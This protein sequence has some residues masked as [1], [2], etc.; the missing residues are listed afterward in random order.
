MP[1]I[2]VC[3]YIYIIKVK[4]PNLWYVATEVLRKISPVDLQIYWYMSKKHAREGTS[5]NRRETKK[6][7][8]K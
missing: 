4:K 5:K 7:Q 1:V 6:T 3:I 2:I 8:N